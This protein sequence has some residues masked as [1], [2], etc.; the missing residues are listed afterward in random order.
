MLDRSELASGI[1]LA[2]MMPTGTRFWPVDKVI[3]GYFFLT[4]LVV[5]GWWNTLPAGS[6]P[7]G[8]A[9]SR[10]GPDRI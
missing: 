7:A 5:L 2:R 6:R 10:F 3:L 4:G 9:Y 1:G 8:L